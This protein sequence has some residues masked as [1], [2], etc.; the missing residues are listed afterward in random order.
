MHP[1]LV[2][3]LDIS[4]KSGVSDEVNI[5]TNATLLDRAPE[6]MWSKI[7]YLRIS[8]YKSLDPA[9]LVIAK[10]RA[11]RHKFGLG[12]DY[13]DKF[14]KQFA[15]H[16]TGDSFFR[17]PWRDRCWTVHEGYLFLCPNAAFFPNQFMGLLDGIDGLPLNEA[18]TED[19][20]SAY[21]KNRKHPFRACEICEPYSAQCE[22]HQCKTREEWVK[23]SMVKGEVIECLQNWAQE[24]HDQD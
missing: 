4:R 18:L 20:L 17:C 15:S 2:A 13:I 16:P 5:L 7:N 22:W 3:L 23:D 12:I 6:A 11:K 10:E 14:F 21:L 8:A 9:Q 19:Q 1:D 24:K